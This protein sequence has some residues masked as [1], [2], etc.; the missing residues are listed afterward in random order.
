MELPREREAGTGKRGEDKRVNAQRAGI[1][2]GIKASGEKEA[3]PLET[4][5]EPAKCNM[6]SHE[7]KA[8]QQ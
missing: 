1:Q 2:G 7:P 4:S 8:M 5:K 3:R 6:L